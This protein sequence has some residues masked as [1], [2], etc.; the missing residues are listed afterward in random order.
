MPL[1]IRPYEEQDAPS[2][3]ARFSEDARAPW[4]RLPYPFT[5]A[6]LLDP[7]SGL[8]VF[9]AAPQPDRA[10]GLIAFDR[11]GPDPLMIGPLVPDEQLADLYVRA[12]LGHALEWART[13]GMTHLRVKVDL[14]EERGLSFFLNQG[15]KLLES[16]QYILAA[17]RGIK[18]PAP[19]PVEGVRFGLS[20]EMLSSDYLRLYQELG[21]TERLNWTRPQ[22]FEHLQR[23]GVHLLSARAGETYLGFAELE[24]KGE[25]AELTH[26]GILPAFRG[27]GIG[28]AFLEHVMSFGFEQLDLERL[29]VATLMGEAEK[30]PMPFFTGHGFRQERA[31]VYLEKKPISATAAK[32]V[33]MAP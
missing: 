24:V 5:L 1:S 31:L 20:P 4:L 7:A 13:R 22:V 25:A 6:R 11:H 8:D 10:V 16:R 14:G 17:R 33:A 23:P 9:V 26:F 29:W 12:L 2:L 21:W 15:F 32:D 27:R 30:G 19:T 3:T 28:G 18:R